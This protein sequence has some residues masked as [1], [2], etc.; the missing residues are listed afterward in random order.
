[1][2]EPFR[3][4][5]L[6]VLDGLGLADPEKGNAI[7]EAG[8]PYLNSLIA[9]Y[10]AMSIA[11]SGLVVGLPWGQPGNSE[12]GHAAIGTGR[13][14][15]QDLAH[16]NH[17]IRTGD[18]FKNE[19]L[20]ATVE[21]CKKYSSALHLMGCTSPGGIHAH[22]DHLIAILE[23]AHEHKLEKVYV[24][25]I[26]DGQDMPP[27][28]AAN[29]LIALAPHLKKT[30]TQIASVQGRSFA[31]DRVLNW[32]L[33]ERIWHAVVLGDA[34]A[35]T[36]P[37]VYL[38]ESY[39]KGMTDYDIEPATVVEDGIAVGPIRDNDALFFFDYRNDR[40]RQL[41]TPFIVFEGFSE[42]DRIR[43]PRNLHVATMTKYAEELNAP[44]AYP[45]LELPETLGHIVSAQDWRQYRIAEKEKE[46]HVTNF[47]NGGRITPLP[48][49]ERIIVSSRKMK[50]KEYLEHPEMSA[51][52]IVD[53]VLEK[54]EDDA[55]LYVIN[56]ANPDMIG[57][58]GNLEASVKACQ[59]TDDA[60]KQIIESIKGDEEKVVIIT[61]DHG[62]AEE[63]YDPATGQEGDTQHSARNV[64]M[65]VIAPRF[66]GKGVGMTLETLAQEVP[67]G[68]LVDVA[69]TTLAMLGLAQ[70]EQMS[71]SP[72]LELE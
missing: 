61:A 5:F 29:V 44:I 53:T 57:H 49:E 69:P 3:K 42:F 43:M 35:I 34:P 18:F 13:I 7:T 54:K 46:A 17:E 28:D 63:L 12:V 37:A 25:F 68:S 70:P 15:V 20:L 26:A 60:I 51:Q 59:V 65:I 33:T 23:L 6:I 27:Q 72:L 21:H 2:A 9:E 66:K 19:T 56:F 52:K 30:G 67:V 64:P 39:A 58:T 50:G 41:A 16:I 4:A 1:M 62:N 8:M 45:P 24:H 48:G 14:I 55:R 22:T 38:Q 71:G 32:P 40:A 31:M 10:P 11:A 36:E 47:L